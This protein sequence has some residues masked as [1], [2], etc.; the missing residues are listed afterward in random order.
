HRGPHSGGVGP[1][2]AA[3]LSHTARPT[4]VSPARLSAPGGDAA[5]RRRG[6]GPGEAWGLPP[7]PG[8]APLA[9]RWISHARPR[10]LLWPDPARPLAAPA[11]RPDP[12]L[13]P[14]AC[15]PHG[16]HARWGVGAALHVSDAGGRPARRR[17]LRRSGH[18]AAALGGAPDADR[19]GAIRPR[20]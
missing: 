7:W 2:D 5:G 6:A 17:R 10:A 11:R 14:L 16:G 15:R 1:P 19:T 20:A 4:G 8:S 9:H 12:A 18:P 3:W 13:V